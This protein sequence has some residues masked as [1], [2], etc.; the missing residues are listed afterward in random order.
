MNIALRRSH[1]G[2]EE[3]HQ[4][5]CTHEG[6]IERSWIISLGVEWSNTPPSKNAS[7]HNINISRD[8]VQRVIKRTRPSS[9]GQD[10]I[11]I[12]LYRLLTQQISSLLA[13]LYTLMLQAHTSSKGFMGGLS[14]VFVSLL[15]FL[16]VDLSEELGSQC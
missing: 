14:P 12:V 16:S 10:G 4:R 11:E 6:R 8:E 9:P 1:A 2:D 13:K 15:S 3:L 5:D 7:D